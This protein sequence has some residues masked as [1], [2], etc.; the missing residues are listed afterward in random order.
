MLCNEVFSKI[1]ENWLDCA[2]FGQG[3]A[4]CVGLAYWP[5]Q[6]YLPAVACRKMILDIAFLG[7]A[8]GKLQSG[9]CVLKRCSSEAKP[10]LPKARR[11]MLLP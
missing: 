7:E 5:V 1:R 11:R 4:G 9:G 6:M 3:E 10:G 8:Q 2:L